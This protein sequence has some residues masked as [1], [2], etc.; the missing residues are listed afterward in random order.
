MDDPQADAIS[1]T[2]LADRKRSGGK[3]RAGD[4]MLKPDPTYEADREGFTGRACKPFAIEPSDD[5]FIIVFF[6]HRADFSNEGV[7]ITDCLG[8]VGLPTDIDRF[9]RSAL[10]ANLQMQQLGFCTLDDR[11]IPTPHPG[12]INFLP[13]LTTP[14]R[15][16]P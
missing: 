10:P 12:H 11:D 13:F 2:N 14:P 1:L 15:P 4:A 6:R 16:P 5:L 9:G 7:G 3:R 8:A